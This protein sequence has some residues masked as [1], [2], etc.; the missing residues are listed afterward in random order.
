MDRLVC[1]DVGFGKTEW[2]SVLPLR[3]WTTATSRYSCS[4]HDPCLSALQ[5]LFKEITRFPRANQLS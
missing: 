2:Q 5:H 4:H 1:G 3:P